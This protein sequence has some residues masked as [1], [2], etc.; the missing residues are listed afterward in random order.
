M[1]PEEFYLLL[2][3]REK[4]VKKYA[5][6]GFPERAGNTV[7]DFIDGNFS[8]QGWQGNAFKRWKKNKRGGTILVKTGN[9]RGGSRLIRKRTGDRQK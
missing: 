5:A 2:K 6:Y 9:L 4:K 8:A 3:K 1:K 7:L